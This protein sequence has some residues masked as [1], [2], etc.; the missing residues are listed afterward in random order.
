[1]AGQLIIDNWTLQ[2][3]NQAFQQGLSAEEMGEI[4]IEIKKDSHDFRF[5][6]KAVFQIDALLTLLVNIV[7]RDCLIVDDR[8]TY[9]WDKGNKSLQELKDR[10]ILIPFDFLSSEE[11][12]AGPRKVVVEELCV[13]RTIREIQR[14]NEISWEMRGKSADAHMSQLVWGCAGYLARSHVYEAPY[15]GCPYRQALIRQTRFVGYRPDAV[16]EMEHIVS[17]KRANLFQSSFKDMSAKYATFNLPPIAVEIIEESKDPNQLITVAIQLRDKY[18]KLR[19]WLK[20]YQDA[21]DTEDPRSMI[22]HR[23]TLES[24]ASNIESKYFNTSKGSTKISVGTSWFLIPKIDISK[25]IDIGAVVDKLTSKFDVRAML[26][27]LILKPGGGE[28]LKKLL[29]L[30]GEKNS[31]LSTKIYQHQIARYSVKEQDI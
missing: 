28:S 25:T 26:N 27:D 19:E 5:M 13:T 14:A 7:L 24:A 11:I 20:T 18:E 6:P 8:F 23:N 1:M 21:L 29:A 9:S 3:V 4:V 2:D 30:F 16:N 17:T 15:L 22:E 31:Q 12:I 10:K